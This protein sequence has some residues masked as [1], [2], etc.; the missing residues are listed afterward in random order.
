MYPLSMTCDDTNEMPNALSSRV[1]EQRFPW[2]KKFVQVI[3]HGF[4]LVDSKIEA[5]AKLQ[6]SGLL[7][8]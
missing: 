1:K 6:S 7:P 8:I 5:L 3:K 2:V 4:F